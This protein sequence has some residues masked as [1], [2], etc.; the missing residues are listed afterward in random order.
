MIKKAITF[1]VALLVLQGAIYSQTNMPIPNGS[2]EQWTSHPGY[3]VTVLGMSLPVY[4][5]Y[6]TPT[7]WGYLAYPVN[8]SFSALGTPISISTSIPLVK[9]VEET[10]SVPDSN[11]AVKLQTFMLSDLVTGLVYTLAAPQMDTM[12]TQ[13]VFPSI[14]L[15]GEINMDSLMPI[16]TNLLANIDSAGDM[17]VSLA[18]TDVNNLITGGIALGGFEPSRLTGSYKYHSAVSGDNGGVL[19][20]GTHYNTTTH[21]RE[22]VGGGLNI[23][24][25]DVANYTPFTVD[26]LSLHTLDST[27]ADQAP[28]SLIVLMISSASENRQ[29]GSYLCVDNLRLWHDST[30]VELPDT[31]AS[32]VALAATADIHE[33]VVAWNT[34]SAVD[35][36]ELEYGPTGFT[37]GSGTMLYPSTTTATLTSL[38]ANTAYDVYVRTVCNGTTYGEWA[39]ASF[40]TQPDTCASVCWIE[41]VNVVYDAFPEYELQWWGSSQPDHWEVEYGLQGFELGS[42]TVVETNESSFAIY[43]L[44]QQGIL[45]P[46]TWYDFYVRSVCEGGV[47]GEWDSVQYRTF[48]ATVEDLT[49]VDDNISVNAAN[50][51][52]GYKVT[53]VDN[54]GTEQWSVSYGTP[55]SYNWHSETVNEPFIQLEPLRPNTRYEVEVSALCGEDN[56]GDYR[57]VGFTTINVGIAEADASSLSV[58]PNPASGRCVVSLAVDTPAELKLYDADGRLLQTIAYKGTPIELQLPSQGVFLLQATT[59]AGTM[60]RKIVNK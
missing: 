53:W 29:Q 14:L 55:N 19:M 46:N 43:E 44:E 54:S 57:Y 39:S 22:V 24:L 47:Y 52:E 50:F 37:Q 28:D 40:A 16:V 60:T 31:C 13:T 15:T 18:G 5:S 17:L 38:V 6:S 12:L 7:G 4:D 41:A 23:G 32:I 34:T 56:Y 10:G 9:V 42:G 25:T 3:N 51:I 45:Q 11:K 1:C 36:Y 2:F 21:R 59:A 20:L 8:E 26:Y 49:L 30:G 58:S 33:A 35:G 27:F 48:C